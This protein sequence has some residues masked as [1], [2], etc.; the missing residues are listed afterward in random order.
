[1]LSITLSIT[2]AIFTEAV[3]DVMLVAPATPIFLR[4]FSLPPIGIHATPRDIR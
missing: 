2:A 4:R 3:A 1:M